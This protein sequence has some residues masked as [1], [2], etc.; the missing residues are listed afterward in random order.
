MSKRFRIVI[1]IILALVFLFVMAPS[2]FAAER[3]YIE[4][5][6]TYDAWAAQ[7]IS[8]FASTQLVSKGFE[9]IQDKSKADKVFTFNVAELRHGV[10]FNWFCLLLPA[11]PLMPITTSDA[12]ASVHLVVKQ[13]DTLKFTSSLGDYVKGHFICGDFVS[14]RKLQQKALLGSVQKL[15]NNYFVTQ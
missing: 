3:V 4:V 10:K 2:T 14:G 11:W 9:I 7:T 6:S 12:S 15:L 8:E 13:G 1:P 5:V